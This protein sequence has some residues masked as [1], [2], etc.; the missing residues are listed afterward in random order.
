M[1]NLSTQ[2]NGGYASSQTST[3]KLASFNGCR[4]INNHIA[5]TESGFGRCNKKASNLGVSPKATLRKPRS[6]TVVISVLSISSGPQ[7]VDPQIEKPGNPQVTNGTQPLPRN[8]TK[9][10]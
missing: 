5:N 4:P 2:L 7:T 10:S 6:V 8:F 9:N 3:Q 1:T